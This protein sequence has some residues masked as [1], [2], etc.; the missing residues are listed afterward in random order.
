MVNNNIITQ[1]VNLQLL[2][3]ALKVLK[4]KCEFDVVNLLTLT[5]LHNHLLDTTSNGLKHT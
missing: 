2:I 3:F 1:K 4:S 5:M